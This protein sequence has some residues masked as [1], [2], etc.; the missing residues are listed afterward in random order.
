M[1]LGGL[2]TVIRDGRLQTILDRFGIALVVRV[3]C[4]ELHARLVLASPQYFR[5]IERISTRYYEQTL[6]K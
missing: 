2:F 3:Y 4:Q 6:L 1:S 5:A